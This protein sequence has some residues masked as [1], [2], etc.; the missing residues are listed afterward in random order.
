MNLDSSS[1]DA[2]IACCYEERSA[3]RHSGQRSSPC[4]IQIFRRAFAGDQLAWAAVDKIFEPLL[5]GW[6]HDGLRKFGN[7]HLLDEDSLQDVVQEAKFILSKVGPHRPHLVAGDQLDLLLAFWRTCTKHELLR[8]LRKVQIDVRSFDQN[9]D[10]IPPD[11]TGQNSDDKKAIRDRLVEMP[12]TEDERLIF[13]L[14]LL[15]GYKPSEIAKRFPDRF[16]NKTQVYLIY[17]RVIRRCLADP[18]LRELAGIRSDAAAPADSAQTVAQSYMTD[19]DD[20]AADVDDQDTSPPDQS[21]PDASGGSAGAPP[22]GP[23]SLELRMDSSFEKGRAMD[24]PCDLDEAILFAYLDD[25]VSAEQRLAIESRPACLA[26]VRTIAAE[27]AQLEALLYRV[28]CPDSEQL[29]AYQERQLEGTPLLVLRQ[30][31]DQC[32]RCQEELALIEALDE[33]PLEVPG[34]LARVRQVIEAVRQSA[35]TL[36]LRGQAH[37]Y[38]APQVVITLSLRQMSGKA[39]RWMLTGALSAA[40]GGP[41]LGQVEQVSLRGDEMPDQLALLEPDGTFVV[42]NLPAGRY[43]LTIVTDHEDV[44]IKTLTI[45]ELDDA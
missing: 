40:D 9:P 1:L 39:P 4:C 45:G 8:V 30:H 35:L 17:Q 37:I 28:T 24:M 26:R 15:Q 2:M 29:V 16:P 21:K 34:P 19:A 14:R 22:R 36:Q 12:Q 13:N 5:K 31:L 33:V 23:L 38:T 18:E 44:L 3:F 41:F 32:Q 6:L 20:Q 11:I 43:Q 10:I 25:Q 42:R 7:P 27:I